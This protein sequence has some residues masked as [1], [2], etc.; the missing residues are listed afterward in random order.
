MQIT[1]DVDVDVWLMPQQAGYVS[2]NVSDG[3]DQIS[4]C[5][6]IDIFKDFCREFYDGGAD[7]ENALQ[8]AAFLEGIAAQLRGDAAGV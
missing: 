2:V 6:R 8:W 3:N 1:F 7:E 4:N 5:K